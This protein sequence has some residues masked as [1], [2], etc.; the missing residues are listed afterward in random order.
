[1]ASQSSLLATD[2][3]LRSGTR[4]DRKAREV[5]RIDDEVFHLQHKVHTLLTQAADLNFERNALVSAVDLPFEVLASIFE[6]AC[7]PDVDRRFMTSID[8]SF[9]RPLSERSRS[10]IPGGIRVGPL[11][12]SRVC[13][14]WRKVALKS[15]KLWNSIELAVDWSRRG[16]QRQADLLDYWLSKSS[17]LP[18]SV[19]LTEDWEFY[20]KDHDIE[21]PTKVIDVLQKYARRLHIAELLIPERWR[22]ALAY[23]GNHA[24][25]L[26][27]LALLFAFRCDSLE[28]INCFSDAL[29][30]L[31]NVALS[32]N[33]LMSVPLP[34]NQIKSL[35]LEKVY[36]PLHAFHLYPNLEHCFIDAEFSGIQSDGEPVEGPILRHSLT[37]LSLH[38][39]NE[40]ELAEILNIL[41]L[42]NLS[43]FTVSLIS[44]ASPLL[45]MVDFFIQSSCALK[46][47]HLHCRTISEDDLVA[48][49][50]AL[51]T[52]RELTLY[53]EE[54]P[55]AVFELMNPRRPTESDHEM[56]VHWRNNIPCLVP[57]L[58]VFSCSG[59]VSFDSGVVIE[60]LEERWQIGLQ[61][62]HLSW[63]GS[64]LDAQEKEILD[65]LSRE[66]AGA[67]ALKCDYDK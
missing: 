64:M 14:A 45:T 2:T 62:A 48:C 49:L 50:Q 46:K 3:R 27:S 24:T 32:R 26:T 53:C 40:S 57:N 25:S 42:P 47:L 55:R 10:R 19:R 44:G 61:S 31:R 34:A 29:P 1:M 30:L 60:F 12:I 67:Y 65:R 41:V 63:T 66:G 51:P 38:L 39:N 37:S 15:P 13:L 16:A 56:S 28:Y 7:W 52:L 54:I 18:I 5:A 35:H 11:Y 36:N 9:W 22:H 59:P 23:I 4:A 58:E 17:P 20:E 43:S 6:F 33:N 8:N 21:M